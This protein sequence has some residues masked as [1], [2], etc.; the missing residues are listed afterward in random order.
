MAI[1]TLR[2]VSLS[3]GHLPLLDRIHLVIEKGDRICL[4]GRNGEGK[5]TLLKVLSGD[6]Q[7]DEGELR[8][9]QLRI[10]QLPQE[11]PAT[12][13]GRVFDIVASG[14]GEAGLLLSAFHAASETL[15]QQSTAKNLQ[16][17]QQ[18]QNALE[19]VGG[20]DL[21]QRTDE[22]LSRLD[23]QA[24]Q[25]FSQLSGGLKR[26]V[27]LACALVSDPA[28][29][30]LDEPTNHLDIDTITWLE[31][32]L[33]SWHGTLLFVSHDRRFLRHLATRILDLDRGQLGDWPG[34]YANYLRRKE[35]MFHA[36]ELAQ[37]RF[38]KKLA[39]EEKWIRKGIQARRTRNQ[40]RVRQLRKM[41]DIRLQRRQRHGNVAMQLHQAEH[42]GKIVCVAENIDFFWPEKPEQLVV[43][44]FSNTILR[45]DRVAILGPNG[46]GKSTLL[47]LLLGNLQP[48]KGRVEHGK[49]LEIAYFDQMRAVLNEQKTVV[50]TVAE[51]RTEVTVNGKSRHVISYL[52]DFLFTPARARQPVHALSGGERNRLLLARMFTRA[53]NL[54]ILDEPTNDL[55]VETLELLEELLLEYTGTLLLVSH[56]REF[57][58]QVV[59]ST[60]VFEGGGKIGQYLG[61]YADWLRQRRPARVG[62]SRQV[63]TA[64]ILAP[65]SAS[66][67]RKLSYREQ[68]ELDAL[69]IQIDALEQQQLQLQKRL[70]DPEIYRD[71]AAQAATLGRNL[72][73]L[74]RQLQDCYQ[75]WEKLEALQGET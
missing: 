7:P 39:E 10:A 47:N 19:Q 50:D 44:H 54:L 26:R 12:L 25:D 37:N 35:E 66:S 51:G 24:D 64:A 46:C 20:W 61:G 11:V 17:L 43:K 6:I 2:H 8:H 13:S 68:R 22:V 55:D 75:R 36:E 71:Q 16:V 69:P 30:L 65:S 34:D 53:F 3:Y 14:L 63:S 32:F 33:L 45:G 27:L 48:T 49:R 58:D 67:R 18:T 28:L 59:T 9:D 70:A 5:S 72:T 15:G 31:D 73:E 56:D 74:E 38:D 57:V 21:Q 62:R 52:Q 29:L 42:S 23:L 1:L 60:L 40:G 41:R 4:I